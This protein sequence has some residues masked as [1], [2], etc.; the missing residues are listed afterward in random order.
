MRFPEQWQLLARGGA[1][2]F[3]YLTNAVGDAAQ[4]PVWR[5]HLVSR[6]A[7]NQRFVLAAN[8]AHPA[9]KCPS[10]IVTPGGSVVWETLS[11]AG[12]S[13]QA[14]LD[15]D[16]VADWYLSQSRRDLCG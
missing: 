10:M 1:Q 3:A 12:A 15:L 7:E 11:P 9:Q 16:A 6:A 8:A 5:S 2:I 13:G 4:A 14:T